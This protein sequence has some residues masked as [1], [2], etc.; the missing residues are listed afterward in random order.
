MRI[1]VNDTQL[2]PHEV[3]VIVVSGQEVPWMP[4]NP[5]CNLNISAMAPSAPAPL[6][7]WGTGPVP[8][9]KLG[10]LNHLAQP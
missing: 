7:A 1:S 4:P 9:L 3:T 5:P 10:S 6:P 8:L 2:S